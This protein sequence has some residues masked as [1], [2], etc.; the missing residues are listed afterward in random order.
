[1]TLFVKRAPSTQAHFFHCDGFFLC[2]DGDIPSGLDPWSYNITK[3]A[4]NMVLAH[5]V[6]FL[7]GI[8]SA[9]I[10]TGRHLTRNTTSV[11]DAVKLKEKL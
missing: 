1:M 8:M 7:R 10:I 4:A 11:F 2:G 5:C 6:P 9:F 3:E